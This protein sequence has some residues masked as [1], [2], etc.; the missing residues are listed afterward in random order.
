MAEAVTDYLKVALKP[1][2]NIL[3][4]LADISLAPDK[5]LSALQESQDSDPSYWP[6]FQHPEVPNLIQTLSENGDL[7]EPEAQRFF[8]LFFGE[9]FEFCPESIGEYPT[10]Y[11]KRQSRVEEAITDALVSQC[12]LSR[13]TYDLLESEIFSFC[14][15]RI[16]PRDKD[17]FRKHMKKVFAKINKGLPD[18]EDPV[19]EFELDIFGRL[20]FLLQ[21]GPRM[22]ILAQFKGWNDATSEY[23]PLE[24]FE[25]FPTK[26]QTIAKA[27]FGPVKKHKV[28]KEWI[29]SKTI[30]LKILERNKQSKTKFNDDP[31]NEIAAHRMLCEHHQECPEPSHSRPCPYIIPLKGVTKDDSDSK[32]FYYME[33]GTDYFSFISSTYEGKLKEW[34]TWLR[35][36]PN[37]RQLPKTKKS[38]WEEERCRDFVKLAEGLHFMHKLGIAH[39]DFKL[40][41]IVKGLDG[42]VK[43]IDFGVAHRFGSWERKKM[44]CQDRVGTATYMSP[45]CTFS[46]SEYR[47]NDVQL[48]SYGKWDAA[49]NDVWTLGIALFM[50]MFACPPYDACSNNDTRFVYLTAAKYHPKKKKNKIPRNANL[51]SLVKAYQRHLMVTDD[52]LDF[53]EKFFLPE[54]ERITMD[55]IWQHKWLKDFVGKRNAGKKLSSSTPL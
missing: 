48:R 32:L 25:N 15:S 47:K 18:E 21:Q 30:N 31:P 7:S 28:G 13:A 2:G 9:D 24:E 27:Y 43:I 22:A 33:Y 11:A 36:Q 1:D 34:K 14:V 17:E 3:K 10:F 8:K 55:Q 4:I 5:F 6:K 45:E 54:P 12:N 49:A 53:L 42:D 23:S 29:V 35:V 41:N 39:R 16:A 51:R 37:G 20:D 44:L 19:G 40:E 50:M 52:C 38:P 46:K 26:G